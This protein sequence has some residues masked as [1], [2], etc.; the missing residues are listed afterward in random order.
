[1]INRLFL[2]RSLLLA[3]CLLALPLAG[4]ARALAAAGPEEV[5]LTLKRLTFTGNQ[6]VSTKAL[7]KEMTM[8]LPSFWPWKKLPRFKEGD[9]ERDL[10]RLQ[11]YYRT[12]G[13]FHTRIT[14]RLQTNEK[15]QVTAELEIAEGPWVKVAAINLKVAVPDRPVDLKP[16]AEKGPLKP[17]DRLIASNYEDLKRLYL[18]YLLNHGYA[19]G[20]VEGKVYV[21]EKLN[22]AKID[23]HVTPGVFSHFGPITVTG[24]EGTPDYLIMRKL[25]FKKGE[26]FDFEKVYESQRNLY[27]LDLFSSVAIV[28]EKV[29]AQERII[30]MVIKVQEKKKR[31]VK[32]GVGFGDEDLLRVRG[33]LRLRNL[34]GGGRTFDLEGKYSSIESHF[35]STF[36]NPQIWATYFD[37]VGAGGGQFLQYPSFDDLAVFGQARLERQLPWQFRGY[38]GYLLQRDRP[39]NIA[40]STQLAFTQPQERSF[41]SSVAFGGLSQDTTDNEIYPTRGGML[42]A[43]GEASPHFL[44]ANLQFLRAV[45]EAR[46]YLNLWE[47]KLILAG[48]VKLGLMG[49]IGDTPEIPLFRRFFCGGYNSVRGYRLYYLGPRDASG[50]PVGGDALM[51]GSGELRFPIYKELRGVIFLDFGN[52]FPQIGNLDVGQLKYAAGAGL[53]YQT[54]IGPVGIDVGVPLNPIDRGS[55]KVQVHFT[56]GQ[57][58]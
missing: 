45:L 12:Q 48:R 33:A 29:A 46:R 18:N 34:G 26:V 47:K 9:L 2:P 52:V 43:R 17:G 30:P 56:I 13:F 21:N 58:F 8:P 31:A 40:F 7:K 50:L 19:H 20:V 41:L 6:L 1:M 4:Y 51:E 44:G 37:L 42:S 25:T 54:P 53:R 38:G 14:P 3:A 28:P 23:L 36:T 32:F 39:T 10:G 11:A 57:A 24:N 35:T 16:L 5:P 27:K 15:R 49:P 55:D 22:T